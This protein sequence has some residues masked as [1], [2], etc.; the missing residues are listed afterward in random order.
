[1][2]ANFC[3]RQPGYWVRGFTGELEKLSISPR[4]VVEHFF[5]VLLISAAFGVAGVSLESWRRK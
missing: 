2:C 3:F 5:A 4:A 1:M